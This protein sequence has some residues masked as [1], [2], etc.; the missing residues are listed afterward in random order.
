MRMH[1]IRTL[2]FESAQDLSSYASPR[3]TLL[4]RIKCKSPRCSEPLMHPSFPH[5][6]QDLNHTCTSADLQVSKITAS[7]RARY[8]QFSLGETRGVTRDV[9]GFVIDT[10][11]QMAPHLLFA[12]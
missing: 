1:E 2:Q 4:E 6:L 7:C 5:L 11:R 9:N 12:R 3:R 10:D 8:D